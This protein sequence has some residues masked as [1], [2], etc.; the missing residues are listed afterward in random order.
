MHA[1]KHRTC[2]QAA[3]EY[4]LFQEVQ[5]RQEAVTYIWYRNTFA[6]TRK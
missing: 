2:I 6:K 5:Q 4:M 1:C 3:E